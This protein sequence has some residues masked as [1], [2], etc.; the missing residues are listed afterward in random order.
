MKCPKCHSE[1]SETKQF[2]GDC[3][4]RLTPSD[5]GRPVFTETLETSQVE[6]ISGTV[7]A[8]RYQVIEELGKGGMGRVYRALDKKLNV[9]VAIKLIKPEI[10]SERRTLERFKNELVLARKVS[11]K[12]VG[13]M[14]DM[15]EETGT[16]YITMEYVP[17]EDLKSSIRR[18]GQLP[19]GK[20]ITIAKQ[21]C[22]GLSEAHKI[23]IVHRDL[24]PSNIMIDKQGNVRIMDFGIARSIKDKGITGEGVIIGT[25]EYMSPEQVEGKDVD[26]R[27]DIY[28]LGIILYEMVTGTP[29]FEGD[30]PL[31]VA[32]RHKSEVPRDPLEVNPQ[33]PED[34]GRVILQCL[35]KEKNKRPQSA[36]DVLA[37]LG[38]IERAIP[39]AGKSTA[40]KRPRTSKE[41]TVTLGIKKPFLAAAIAVAVIAAALLT[42]KLWPKKEV[43]KASI[44]V[45]SFEN[46]TGESSYDYLRKAIPNLLITSLERSKNIEVMTWERMHDLLEQMGKSEVDV[47]DRDLGF[48]LCRR[49]GVQAIVLGSFV[50]AGEMF[51]TDVKVLDVSTKSILKSA[52]S[53]GEGISSILKN[54]V[55]ELSREISKGIGESTGAYS[56]LNRS[57]AEV[58]TESMEAY[59]VFL[60]GKESYDKFYFD[61]AKQDFE[62]ALDL[63]PQFAMAHYM[64]GETC[65]ELG[66]RD[67]G[68]EAYI[69]ANALSSR[70]TEKERLFIESQYVYWSGGG[71]EK[72]LKILQE[73][74]NKYPKEKQAHNDLGEIYLSREMYEEAVE[75]FLKAIELDPNWGFVLN[76][77]G[78][79]YSDMGDFEKAIECFER[80]AGLSPGDANPIDS[81]AE[82][83]F[84][85]GRLDDAIRKYEEALAIK[86]DFDSGLSLSLVYAFKEDYVRAQTQLDRYIAET[87]SS[88]RRAEGYLWKGMLRFLTGQRDQAF[89]F[90]AESKKSADTI[91]SGTADY[92]QGWMHFELGEFDLSRKY[93][94]SALDLFLSFFPDSPGWECWAEFCIGLVDVR[95]G[96]LDSAKS[97]LEAIQT[98]L[99]KLKSPASIDDN[100]FR[101]DW[102]QAEILMAQ[103]SAGEAAAIL[104][105]TTPESVPSLQTDDYGPYNLPFRRDVLARAYRQCGRLDDAITEYER[106]IEFVPG[107]K[108]RHLV[109]PIY[110]FLLGKLYEEKTLTAEALG[111]Y[112]RFLSLWKDA[113]PG[114]PEVEDAKKRLAELRDVP[115][116]PFGR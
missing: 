3:G 22:E 91:R 41:L 15:G 40:I 67:P 109:H 61:E 75:S 26:Q 83:Y 46:Q 115:R 73:L 57:I 99:P 2:C 14:F 103:G 35:E 71:S 42:W 104:K 107:E 105:D 62:R 8:G 69:K 58:T 28:S 31:A 81:M 77:L 27:S 6:L 30:T 4:T 5:A 53:R 97:R 45:I 39:T 37:S 36:D 7:F 65:I 101:R 92:T 89:V 43:P 110:Y 18:F 66:E 29:P 68:I 56:R 88:G 17:G 1:N 49:D 82:Q 11:Q 21:V 34:L 90:L 23:G 16:H 94:Q 9:E 63:D 79:V 87:A 114:L 19:I 72:R 32:V 13:R 74:V 100:T 25:P 80:Y 50:M 38:E 98:I 52:S 95:Q 96:R 59:Q 85:M 111:C 112:E 76:S 116:L 54:Q 10:A 24:K 51:A 60:K 70:A 44:A 20:S 78:Y 108:D 102:L 86:P 113:D 106:L 64:L 12:N 48:E 93:L 47:I 84:R 33:I 55:D